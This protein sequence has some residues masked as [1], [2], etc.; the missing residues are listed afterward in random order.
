M[1]DTKI[2]KIIKE[3]LR[4]DIG[5]GDITTR[6][7]FPK[8]RKISFA[9]RAC[10]DGVVAGLPIAREVFSLSGRVSF[11]TLKRDGSRVKK[12]MVVAKGEG[13]IHSVLAAERTAL[14]FL[15]HLSGI[16]TLT[17]KFVDK[18]KPYRVKILDTR[19]TTPLLRSL[20]KYAVRSGGG[21]NHRF[22]LDS[23]IL[24]KDNH[25]AAVKYGEKD[26][27]HKRLIRAAKKI[28]LEIEADSL[29][30]L[31]K[32][33]EVRPHIV[34]LDNFSLKNLRKAIRIVRSRSPRPQIEVS[35]GVTLENVRRIASSGVERISIGALTHSAPALDFSLEVSPL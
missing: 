18:A 6:V 13:E 4:R 11:R 14:N 31:R 26:A 16:A 34:L 30:R 2:R 8:V 10:Q 5:R 28:K 23:F 22:G 20:E 19:K 25:I 24:V 35:G 27:C 32:V 12:G 9:I 1:I 3:E 29:A 33:L 7:L 17:R 15:C 21:V